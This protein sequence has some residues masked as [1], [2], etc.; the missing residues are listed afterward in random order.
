MEEYAIND[1]LQNRLILE[2]VEK[3]STTTDT[4]PAARSG[5]KGARPTT[6]PGISVE[7]RANLGRRANQKPG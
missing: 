1:N 3:N 6:R 7:S 4:N 5:N 2:K